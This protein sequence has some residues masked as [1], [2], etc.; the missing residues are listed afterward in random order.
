MKN[1]KLTLAIV[2]IIIAA[3]FMV[4]PNTVKAATTLTTPLYF[5]IQEFRSGTTP[6]NIAYAINNPLDNGSTTDSIVGTKIWQ[7]VK[8]NNS[9]GT[10]NYTTGNYYCV[11]AGVGFSDTSKIATYNIS[12]DLKTEKS[13]RSFQSNISKRLKVLYNESSV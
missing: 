13:T 1:K 10:G 12:Y 4:I 2:F 3:I 7:I 6:E 5:G 11:R 8:Y 9:Q